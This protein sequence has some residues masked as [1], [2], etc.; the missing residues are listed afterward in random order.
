M[1]VVARTRRR[2]ETWTV[3]RIAHDAVPLGIVEDR[4]GRLCAVS[5]GASMPWI[6]ALARRHGVALTLARH[7][8]DAHRQL[9]EY[10][11]GTREHFDL[12]LRL[13]GTAFQK[14]AWRKLQEVG[15][16][17]TCTYGELATAM[18]KPK[19]VRAVGHAN[20]QNPLPIVVP[21]HRVI[22]ADGKLTGF[23]GGL[24]MKRWLLEHESNQLGLRPW[25][26]QLRSQQL[27]LL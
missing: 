24:S 23:R 12:D 21:C 26:P 17:E 4:R 1:G 19:A 5:L 2:L 11:A 10:L 14:S 6:R 15:F 25:R 27:S 8:S 13:L 16:G 18:G 3:D 7:R 20:G 22:G 9:C